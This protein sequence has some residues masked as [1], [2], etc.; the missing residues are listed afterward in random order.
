MSVKLLDSIN[1]EETSKVLLESYVPDWGKAGTPVWNPKYLENLDKTY[2]Q[3]NNGL[4]VGAFDGNDLIGFGCGFVTNWNV[5]NVGKIVAMEMCFL[6][7]LPNHQRKGLATSMVNELANAASNKEID[8]VYRICNELLHDEPL[9]EK[10]GFTK[11]M[12]NVNQSGR[13]LGSDMLNK[14]VKFRE[15]GTALKTV[16][17]IVAGM[18]K[19]SKKLPEG[20]G[21][22]RDGNVNDV[23]KCV[24]LL[25]AY[26]GSTS[27]S[28]IWTE[29][30]FKVF[31][32]NKDLL[33]K[34]FKLFF[35]VLEK[36]GENKGFAVGR[37]EL[38]RYNQGDVPAAIIQDVAFAS[39]LSRQVKTGFMVSLLYEF[40]ANAPE[41]Y[42]ASAAHV[43]HDEKPFDKAG[44]N[45]DRTTRPLLVKL[46]NNELKSWF[47][48]NWNSYKHY[49]IPYQ[50]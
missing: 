42:G 47:E 24:E 2:L 48:E 32:E 19:E 36:D 14:A 6:G 43:H 5:T 35:R 17:R 40:K 9:L 34:P 21:A 33:A 7:V 16:M 31:L 50:R 38:I 22:I 44:Y 37:Y 20:E 4:Y 11:K 13:L 12:K 1:Y 10:C 29:N 28:R 26:K 27:I 23:K 8:L 15:A 41:A 45:N 49:Y 25:N 46:V 30:E 18:P 3:P 39:D